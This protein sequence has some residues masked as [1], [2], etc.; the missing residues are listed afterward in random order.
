MQIE[1][2]FTQY[3]KEIFSST[4]STDENLDSCL[5]CIE[6]RVNADMNEKLQ[7]LFTREE[8]EEA[9][10]QMAPLKAPRP[11][12]YNAQFFQFYWHI[13]GDEV[14]NTIYN[15]LMGVGWIW[16]LIPLLLL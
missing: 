8:I 6:E 14:C 2:V 15:F 5:S 13:V 12:G 16:G 10:H 11:D 3:F 4:R 9:L 1:G 7:K